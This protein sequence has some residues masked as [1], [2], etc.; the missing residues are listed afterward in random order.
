MHARSVDGLEL[1][2]ELPLDR[3]VVRLGPIAVLLQRL[4]DRH[5]EVETASA[6]L[7]RDL[8]RICFRPVP[9]TTFPDKVETASI[10]IRIDISNR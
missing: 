7:P 9:N 1:F 4:G 2:H 5:L 10:N 6:N 8:H 3:S